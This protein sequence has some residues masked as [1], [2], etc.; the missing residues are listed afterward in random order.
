[1]RKERKNCSTYAAFY[2]GINLTGLLYIDQYDG[3]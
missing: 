3:F 2:K 1:M